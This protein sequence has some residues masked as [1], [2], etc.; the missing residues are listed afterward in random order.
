MGGA[1]AVAAIGK[2]EAAATAKTKVAFVS[3]RPDAD[4]DAKYESHFSPMDIPGEVA[5]SLL[6]APIYLLWLVHS[7]CMHQSD[8]V[9]PAN[10]TVK[11]IFPKDHRV[12]Y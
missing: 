11:V 12:R 2:G 9:K 7:P 1:G 6:S 3:P 8:Y 4:V 5:V 10:S